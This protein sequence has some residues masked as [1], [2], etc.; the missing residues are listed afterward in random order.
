MSDNN[1]LGNSRLNAD[2]ASARFDLTVPAQSQ[3]QH[4]Q[5]LSGLSAIDHRESLNLSPSEGLSPNMSAGRG[6]GQ[7]K[8]DQPRLSAQDAKGS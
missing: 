3:K 6:K 8:K 1:E 7:A 2:G 5:S 4:H